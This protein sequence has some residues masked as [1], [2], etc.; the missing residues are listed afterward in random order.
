MDMI[1]PQNVF[2]TIREFNN[3]N[4]TNLTQLDYNALKSSIPKNWKTIFIQNHNNISIQP[5][6]PTIKI[7]N[8]NKPISLIKSKYMYNNL[9]L[10]KI[11]PPAIDVDLQ[12]NCSP[13]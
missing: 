1:N 3:I 2:N 7:G 8:I 13:I 11:K 9:I 12:E 10:Y 6:K 5:I 4:K